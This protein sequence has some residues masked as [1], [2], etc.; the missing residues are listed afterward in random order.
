M[1]D[2]EA[3]LAIRELTARYNLAIDEGRAEE[4]ADTFVHDGVFESTALGRVAGRAAL[5]E[6]AQTF[7]KR[8][9]ARHCT[10]DAIIEVA[11]DT[12]TQTCYLIFIGVGDGGVRLLNSGVY[13]DRLRHTA[14]GWRFVER[15]VAPDTPVE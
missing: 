1:S 7:S 5:V 9:H 8:F 4:W 11:G 10:T 6:F 3:K 12:A 14:A 15:K 2:V 13:R